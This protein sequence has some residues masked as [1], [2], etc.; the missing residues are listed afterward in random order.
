MTLN[1]EFIITPIMTAGAARQNDGGRRT[2]R[3]SYPAC[4]SRRKQLSGIRHIMPYY[5]IA[6]PGATL[7]YV[8]PKPALSEPFCEPPVTLT[9]LTT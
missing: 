9:N 7:L 1:P 2:D 3:Y 6:A 8:F 5:R 4:P